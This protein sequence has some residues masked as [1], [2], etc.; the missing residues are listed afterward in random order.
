[1]DQADQATI[2]YGGEAGSLGDDVEYGLCASGA[3]CGEPVVVGEGEDESGA[4]GCVVVAAVAGQIAEAV[5]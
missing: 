3:G 4:F 2:E 5:V 1:M